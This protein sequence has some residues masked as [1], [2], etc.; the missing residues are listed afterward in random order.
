MKENKGKGLGDEEAIQEGEEVHSQPCP[1]GVKKRKTLSKMVYMES[2]PSHRGHKRARH[3]S[4]KPGVVKASSFIP[5]TPTKQP[6]I[7]Q[8]LNVDPSNPP[9][10]TPSKPPSGSPMTLLRSEGLSWERF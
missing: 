1:S 2:L 6:P 5:P 3:G 4:S 9:E 8:I 7:I 10:V